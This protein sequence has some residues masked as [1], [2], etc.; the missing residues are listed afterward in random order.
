LDNEIWKDVVGYEGRYQVSNQGRV[1]STRFNRLLK[2]NFYK[3]YMYIGLRVKGKFKNCLVHTLVLN[4]FV[5]KRPEGKE[6]CHG[7]GNPR[8][9]TLENLRWGTN[10]ENVQDRILHGM[11]GRGVKHSQ[12]KLTQIQVTY[13]R[14]SPKTGVALA[15]QFNMSPGH[16]SRIK[17]GEGW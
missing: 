3:K 4:A 13:I 8:N 7:D 16:I 1:K 11:S 9:N 15:K 2:Q 14:S 17:R 5:S 6:C 12:A 10:A